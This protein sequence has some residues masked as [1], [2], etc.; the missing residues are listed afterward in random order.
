M[1]GKRAS[2]LPT[3]WAVWREQSLRSTWLAQTRCA[4]GSV[5]IRPRVRLGPMGSMIRQPTNIVILHPRGNDGRR[6]IENPMDDF[7]LC[8]PPCGRASPLS[9]R[10]TFAHWARLLLEELRLSSVGHGSPPSPG[11]I[12]S[13]CV[14]RVKGHCIHLTTAFQDGGSE[15]Q[16]TCRHKF[17]TVFAW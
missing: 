10:V 11:P 12:S 9:D 4:H 6:N 17:A 7:A 1:P 5:L 13:T 8:L 2:D 14:R 15:T 16:V 3:A